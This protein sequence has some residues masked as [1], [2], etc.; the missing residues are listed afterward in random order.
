MAVGRVE[1]A[2]DDRV[3]LLRIV[4]SRQT[5][6][7]VAARARI[8]LD[9]ADCGV[10]EAARRS[11]VSR[12]TAV[13][14]WK[15]YQEGGVAALE[16]VPRA[17]RPPAGDET[18]RR[19]LSCSLGDPPPGIDR[20]TT[21][22][23]AEAVGASQATVS[24]VR[25]RFFPHSAPSE[26]FPLSYRPMSILSYVGV[27]PAGCA[28]GFHAGSGA[29]TRGGS[30]RAAHVE[31]VE[32]IVCA[33]LLRRPVP[34]PG[35]PASGDASGAL[36]V[37]CRAAKR[38]AATPVVDLVID[39]ELDEKARR[40]LADRPW[41]TVHCVPGDNWFGMVHGIVDMLDPQ[42][43][44]ELREIQGLIR[45]ARRRSAGEFVWSRG[46]AHPAAAG[47]PDPPAAVGLLARGDLAQ[48]VRGICVAIA[49]GE[50]RA[51]DAISPRRIARRAGLASG[52]VAET[53]AHMAEDALV[54]R[55]DGQYRLP[56]P[57]PRDVIDTYTARGLL[58]TAIVR[59]LASVRIDLLPTVD[60]HYLGLVRCN[61][62]GLMSEAHRIDLD[63]QDELARSC[64]MPRIGAMFVRLSMQLRLFVTILGLRYRYPTNE[65]LAEADR[66]L[67]EIRRNDPGAAVAAWHDKID[68]C[69]HYMLDQL[70]SDRVNRVPSA[71]RDAPL[72]ADAPSASSAQR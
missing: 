62:H 33:S 47:A 50:L 16:D 63:F 57:T 23:M 69:A 64:R 18:V 9:C 13:K 44:G 14:W 15:R 3:E 72:S 59:D 40:W 34:G 27:H 4:R 5:P 25:R 12:S 31:A 65:M 21:R 1:V 43:S 28:L 11:S 8:V 49:D 45:A 51:R 48:V 20:W 2:A 26:L 19:I 38:L 61:E 22:T 68:N 39:V 32:T 53:L 54:E 30:T 58:G 56:D 67:L 36:D 7:G 71:H 35:A 37:L 70:P 66:L 42:Q 6:R 10:A 41:I 17:G 55:T 52:R 24:R 46:P 60:E 29:P